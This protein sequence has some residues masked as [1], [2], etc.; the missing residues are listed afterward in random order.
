MS[1]RKG[2][3]MN[4][5]KLTETIIKSIS[6]HPYLFTFGICIIINPFFLGATDNIPSNA[7]WIETFVITAVIFLFG[8]HRY[9]TDNLSRS[10]FITFT[11]CAVIANFS[12]LSLYAS[13][14][15]K[16]LWHF[17]GGY[18]IL[19]ILYCLADSKKYL[20]QLNSLMIIGTGFFLKLHYV[21]Q[22]S[23]YNRQHDMGAFG[24]DAGHAGY[25]EYLLFN[26]HLADFDVRDRWQF[27]HPPLHHAISAVWIYIN[28]NIFLVGRDPARESLQTLT[29]FYSMCIII[30]AYRILRHFKLTG[31]ALYIPLIIIS[32]HPAFIL[33]SGSINNDVL[34]VA[35][36][37][38]AV[39]STLKWYENQTMK[40]ILKI[41]LCIGLGMMT[42]LSA[43]LVAP[44]VA[45]M[46]LIVFIKKIRTD[47]KKLFIQFCSFAAVCCP[48]GLWYG[49]RNY[50]K[51]KIPITYV[52]ELD[53]G[54]LQYIGNKSFLSRITDF[55]PKQF[56]SVFIQWAYEEN[57]EVKGY[58]EYN[59]LI[60]ILKNS[61]FEEGI[62]ESSFPENS[63]MFKFSAVLFIIGTVIAL[64]AFIAMIVT[65]FRKCR[66]YSA[67][68]VFFAVF[69]LT[70][71]INF[72]KMC[73][74]YPFT[75]TM[76]FRYV[77]PTVIIG[78][79]S[80][81]IVSDRIISRKNKTAQTAMKI[82][83]VLTLLFV[84]LTII[85]YL[86]VGCWS[87]Q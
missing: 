60:A 66:T 73:Y 87:V 21:L 78:A 86:S 4:R 59:P 64:Y 47:G 83:E 55:S 70:I 33:L 38:G 22:T 45:V 17:T 39:I 35:F 82:T 2:T 58:N 53:K 29:L 61:L 1:V 50:I 81:G 36:M 23:V 19:F 84:T 24:S 13:S 75:C 80:V 67:E 74:D 79:L 37:L 40:N 16:S 52:Q 41:A 27:Y 44:P 7:L 14:Y 6:A 42:K 20:T 76:N 46:F 63:I 11:I 72:Y 65:L 49:I 15:N 26:H 10:G 5:E 57:G 18:I 12:A 8:F 69:Y 32:F 71:M 77:T 85:I 31:K 34:S 9:K 56:R 54:M 48:L 68:K 30:S 28:E 3:A 25:I 62:N 43:A 51:W